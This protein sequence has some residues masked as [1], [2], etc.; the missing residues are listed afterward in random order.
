MTRLLTVLLPLLC[1]GLFA[2]ASSDS[3][4]E[5]EQPGTS[6]IREYVNTP[7]D[8][9]RGAKRAVERTQRHTREQADSLD[10]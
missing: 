9:A 4:Q 10:E 6:A 3:D 2:C 5:E 7:K 1:I 8:K